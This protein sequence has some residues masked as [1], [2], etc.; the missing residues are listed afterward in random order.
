MGAGRTTEVEANTAAVSNAEPSSNDK[1]K[2]SVDTASA[3][4]KDTHSATTSANAKTS[5]KLDTSGL[6][7]I[8][9]IENSAL[10]G[11]ASEISSYCLLA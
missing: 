5:V 3:A 2:P 4:K 10:R 8:L 1:E 9:P 6:N 7:S 11:F